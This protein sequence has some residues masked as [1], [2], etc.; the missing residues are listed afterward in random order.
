MGHA[1]GGIEH[2]QGHVGTVEG[3]ERPHER[4]VL[5]PLAALVPCARMPAVST[6][7]QRPVV[8]LDE[9]VDGVARRAGQVVHD[10]PLLARRGG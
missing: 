1:L 7:L 6:S 2:E 9:G 5:G 3:R 10:G 8:G 4:V